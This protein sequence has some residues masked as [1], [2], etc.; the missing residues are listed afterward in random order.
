M[1][2]PATL[3]TSAAPAP[4]HFGDVPAAE[5]LVKQVAKPLGLQAGGCRG[6]PVT[7]AIQPTW[8]INANP[9]ASEEMTPPRSG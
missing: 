4:A 5:T 9:P 3:A 1:A 8:H 6:A 7:L 2:A